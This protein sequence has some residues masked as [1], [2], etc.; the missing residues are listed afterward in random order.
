MI[1]LV[2]L[3]VEC[4]GSLVRAVLVF[5]VVG[6]VLVKKIV[7]VVLVD[8]GVNAVRSFCPYSITKFAANL[9]LVRG[10]VVSCCRI[11]VKLIFIV[12]RMYIER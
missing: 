3:H 11:N 7:R 6:N 12:L 4:V 8:S 9:F 1:K 10:C 2:L 5:V